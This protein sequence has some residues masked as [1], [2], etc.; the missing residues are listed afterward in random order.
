[1]AGFLL[2]PLMEP[3]AR[4][5]RELSESCQRVVEDEF[6]EGIAFGRVTIVATRA[7]PVIECRPRG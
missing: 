4:V 5:I 7:G 2:L 6:Y 1:M 3:E